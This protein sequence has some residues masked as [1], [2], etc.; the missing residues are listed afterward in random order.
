MRNDRYRITYG[1]EYQCI[2]MFWGFLVYANKILKRFMV[3]CTLFREGV[4]A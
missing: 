2:D 4:I 1:I 3:E